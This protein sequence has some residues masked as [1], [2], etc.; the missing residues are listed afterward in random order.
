MA[1]RGWG[2]T[3][4]LRASI[5]RIKAMVFRKSLTFFRYELEESNVG[6]LAKIN[7]ESSILSR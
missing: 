6:L 4:Q 3:Y 7:Y 5:S 1:I 2:R